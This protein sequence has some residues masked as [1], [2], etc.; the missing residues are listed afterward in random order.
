MFASVS[1]SL[2]SHAFH[3]SHHCHY[4]HLRFSPTTLPARS[5]LVG[6]SRP[7][8]S[9]T[10]VHIEHH[11][12]IAN[13]KSTSQKLK[14]LE[15]V[16]KAVT[17]VISWQDLVKFLEH[18]WTY[19]TQGMRGVSMLLLEKGPGT[20]WPSWCVKQWHL[21]WFHH[22]SFSSILLRRT[23]TSLCPWG[24][25]LRGWTARVFRTWSVWHAQR[26]RE[27]FAVGYV[28]VFFEVWPS[29]TTYVEFDSV[30]D[31]SLDVLRLC[32]LAY[33]IWYRSLV[34]VLCKLL[35]VKVPAKNL[36]GKE[37]FP[38]EAWLCAAHAF[39]AGKAL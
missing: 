22:V 36:I 38:S 35:Q 2:A 28:A 19:F 31:L 9:A 12:T 17:T 20:V 15:H 14:K 7:K 18:V 13:Q 16:R 29:G 34:A 30:K 33:C 8:C 4:C 24:S 11:R 23:R 26:S 5:A 3:L 6:Q 27:F 21:Q 32:L 37:A 39:R 1:F 10:R 25:P